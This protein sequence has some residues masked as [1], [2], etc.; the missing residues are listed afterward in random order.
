MTDEQ[1]PMGEFRRSIGDVGAVIYSR[2]R[3]AFAMLAAVHA[4]IGTP[5]PAGCLRLHPMSSG[6]RGLCV[7]VTAAGE[8]DGIDGLSS[9]LRSLG[10][11][12]SNTTRTAE[13]QP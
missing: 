1:C 4:S 10:P 5:A 2:L 9:L 8:L 6:R 3:N 12:R 13:L 11:R 7:E